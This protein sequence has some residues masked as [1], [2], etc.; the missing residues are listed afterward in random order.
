MCFLASSATSLCGE[1]VVQPKPGPEH[2]KLEIAVGEWN[3]EGE[4]KTSPFGPAGKFRGKNTSRMVLNGFFVETRWEDKSDVNYVAQGIILRGYDATKKTYVDYGF[5]NDGSVTP[6]SMTVSG[7]TWTG[8]GTRRDNKGKVYQ[9]KFTLTYSADGKSTAEKAEY[10]G[11]NGKTWMTFY[12]L[13]NK[14]VSN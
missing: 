3:Y 1:A 12:E 6:S 14:K 5:E 4:A 2:K 10:S 11:D 13:T 7:N 9:M 8:M